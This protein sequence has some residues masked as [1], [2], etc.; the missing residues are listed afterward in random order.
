MSSE[1]SFIK[2]IKPKI[3]IKKKGVKISLVVNLWSE[4]PTNE[5]TV[6]LQSR[7]KEALETTIGIS[8]IREIKVFVE[9]VTHRGGRLRGVEYTK[10]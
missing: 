9:E 7:V 10:E 5:A 3:V 8:N 1:E 2:T 6:T 4:I